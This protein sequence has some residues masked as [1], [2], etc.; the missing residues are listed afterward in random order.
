MNE[1]ERQRRRRAQM[2]EDRIGFG[3]QM[4]NGAPVGYLR[5]GRCGRKLID[6]AVL[7]GDGGARGGFQ[8]R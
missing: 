5:C 7:G 8:G 1:V 6:E 3:L 2:D 4:N